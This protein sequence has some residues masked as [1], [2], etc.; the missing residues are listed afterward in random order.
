MMMRHFFDWLLLWKQQAH[1]KLL[2][3]LNPHHHP[4]CTAGCRGARESRQQQCQSEHS[5]SVVKIERNRQEPLM[6][7]DK[8]DWRLSF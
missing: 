1:L 8:T 4:D 2:T 6:T 7:H 3:L 5:W